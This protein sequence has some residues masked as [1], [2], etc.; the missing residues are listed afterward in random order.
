[1]VPRAAGARET[2]E[3]GCNEVALVAKRR[4]VVGGRLVGR[5]IVAGPVVGLR[6]ALLTAELAEAVRAGERLF[7]CA[8]VDRVLIVEPGL[9]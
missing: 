3:R 1:M 9:R 7:A 5:R 8:Q 4:Q 2:A 6:G